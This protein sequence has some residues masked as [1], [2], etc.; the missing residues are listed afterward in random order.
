VK[1]ARR[2]PGASA[3]IGAVSLLDDALTESG[4]GGH[5]DRCAAS[6]GSVAGAD[7]S[8]GKLFFTS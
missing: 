1:S 3:V 8:V 6:S 4:A 2:F 7:G 5:G